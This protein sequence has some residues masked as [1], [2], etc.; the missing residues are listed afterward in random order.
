MVPS[1]YVFMASYSYV[2]MDIGLCVFNTTSPSTPTQVESQWSRGDYQGAM[3]SSRTA[4][5]WGIAG[6]VTGSVLIG[7]TVLLNVIA[8][9]VSAGSASSTSND[10]Y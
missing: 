3:S 6:L 5:N 1:N 2:C 7:G 9:A 4:K 8:F 10:D